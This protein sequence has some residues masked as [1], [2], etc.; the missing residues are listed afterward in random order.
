M[1]GK[2]NK[3]K[4][5]QWSLCGR[6]LCSQLIPQRAHTIAH[7]VRLG[8]PRFVY[9]RK[10][11]PGRAEQVG[12]LL[13]KH[14]RHVRYHSLIYVREDKALQVTQEWEEDKSCGAHVWSESPESG[15]HSSICAKVLGQDRETWSSHPRAACAGAREGFGYPQMSSWFI[16]RLQ[17]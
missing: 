13:C 6:I 12:I 14:C 11:G 1:V 3:Q 8:W 17:I 5:Q 9:E 10:G 7:S 2:G 15:V 4:K 16:H